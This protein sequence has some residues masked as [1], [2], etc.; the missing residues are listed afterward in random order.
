MK[1]DEERLKKGEETVNI[2]VDRVQKEKESVE[3]AM[4]ELEAARDKAQEGSGS[5]PLLKVASFRNQSVMKQAALTAGV[6]FSSRFAF[7]LADDIFSG[8]GVNDSFSLSLQ[9]LIALAGYIY[10]FV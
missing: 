8:K 1:M 4:R 9:A 5:G 10:Y 2:L 6:L 3:V 7:G